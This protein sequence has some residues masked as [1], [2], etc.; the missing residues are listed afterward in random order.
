MRHDPRKPGGRSFAQNPYRKAL[1]KLGRHAAPLGWEVVL[2]ALLIRPMLPAVDDAAWRPGM[3]MGRA[4]L[5]SLELQPH[6]IV[7]NRVLADVECVAIC[8]NVD[9]RSRLEAAERLRRKLVTVTIEAGQADDA[10][11]LNALWRVFFCAKNRRRI[12]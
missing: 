8:Q 9:L 12:V 1:A 5:E 3:A 4:N 6:M 2:R 7:I 11:S 10:A